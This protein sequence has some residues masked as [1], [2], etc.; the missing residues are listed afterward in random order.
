MPVLQRGV[1][2]PHTGSSQTQPSGIPGMPPLPINLQH[3]P[4]P[5]PFTNVQ[6]L[7][8]DIPDIAGIS[9]QKSNQGYAAF[10]KDGD[11]K[12]FFQTNTTNAT[13]GSLSLSFV[14]TQTLGMT[15]EQVQGY[16]A[17]Q[18]V[19]QEVNLTVPDGANP[20]LLKTR[21]I[22]KISGADEPM[23]PRVTRSTAREQAGASSGE[24]TAENSQT[25]T[26]NKLSDIFVEN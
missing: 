14:D 3:F 25:N 26:P 6:D 24:S 5:F 22:R 7:T 4:M 10:G 13:G 1:T 21:L 8:G 2:N 18:E 12:G 16:M 20:G 17:T 23:Q 11:L 19:K 9:R 15:D